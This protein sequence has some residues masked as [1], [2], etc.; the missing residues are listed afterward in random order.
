MTDGEEYRI[1]GDS[2]PDEPQ[3]PAKVCR[4]CGRLAQVRKLAKENVPMIEIALG[5]GAPCASCARDPGLKGAALTIMSIM[6]KRPVDNWIPLED[7]G[8][9]P[10]IP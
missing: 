9:G 10:R 4:T 6:G 2:K 7:G 3:D 5:A 1:L 8:D